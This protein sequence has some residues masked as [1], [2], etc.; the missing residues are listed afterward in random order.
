MITEVRSG[1]EILANGLDAL[2]GSV[3]SDQERKC[4]QGVHSQELGS[5]KHLL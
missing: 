3:L 5:E 1:L 4:P 2:D